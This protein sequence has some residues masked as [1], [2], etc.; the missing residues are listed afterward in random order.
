MRAVIGREG[1]AP[2]RDDGCKSVGGHAQAGESLRQ[3]G[4]AAEP[5]NQRA[6][7]ERAARYRR[8]IVHRRKS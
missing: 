5:E 2:A 4:F 3:R 8:P 7:C 1:K 6:A